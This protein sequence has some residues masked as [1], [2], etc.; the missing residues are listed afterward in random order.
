TKRRNDLSFR[1][2]AIPPYRV[3]PYRLLSAHSIVGDPRR[4]QDDQVAPVLAFAG[5]AEQ[6]A[7]DRKPGKERDAGSGLVD[8]RH[9]Q[10]ADDRGLAI[11]DQQ[12]VVGLLLREVEAEVGRREELD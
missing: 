1:R 12:L 6:L 5:E 11:V 10:A 8:L 2:T 9:C 3:P 4:H 7:Y